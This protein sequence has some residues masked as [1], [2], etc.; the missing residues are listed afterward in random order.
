[1]LHAQPIVRVHVWYLVSDT[2]G[3]IGHGS[4]WDVDTKL[5]T[6]NKSQVYANGWNIPKVIVAAVLT[7]NAKNTFYTRTVKSSC[8]VHKYVEVQ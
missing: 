4:N 6:V 8:I 7:S 1:M 3:Q 2:Y 5:S